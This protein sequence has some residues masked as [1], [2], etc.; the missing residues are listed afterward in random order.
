[1][2]E[3]IFFYFRETPIDINNKFTL[4]FSNTELISQIIF[5]TKNDYY[6]TKTN[7]NLVIANDLD[8]QLK[9]MK[10][11]SEKSCLLLEKGPAYQFDLSQIQLAFFR[12]GMERNF[13]NL[14]LLSYP[15]N[16]DFYSWKYKFYDIKDNLI[17]D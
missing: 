6:I 5:F 8:D 14:Y 15:E 4:N 13:N 7:C 1:M 9:D 3:P 2:L 12:Q 17:K 10:E 11:L 16:I